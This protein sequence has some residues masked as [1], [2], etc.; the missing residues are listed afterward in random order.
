MFKYLLSVLVRRW[1]V[2]S[3]RKP[4][5]AARRAT[6]RRLKFECLEDRVVPAGTL[7]LSGTVLTLADTA[8][9]TITVGLASGNYTITDSA[10]L[11]GTITGWTISGNTATETDGNAGTITQLTFNTTGATFGNATTGIAGGAANIAITDAGTVTIGASSILTT[12]G[13]VSI[14]ATTSVVDTGTIG[15]ATNGAITISGPLSGAGNLSMGSAGASLTQ[16]TASTFSGVISGSQNLSKAGAGVL[17]LSGNSTYTGTTTITAGS[18]S[19]GTEGASAGAAG[20]LGAV[21]SSLIANDIVLNG[22]TLLLNNSLTLSANRGIVLGPTGTTAGSGEIDVAA[23]KV[24]TIA[25]IIANNGNSGTNDT[26]IVGSS[27]NTGILVL[28]GNDTY[29]GGTS[30]NDGEILI[31][32]NTALGTGKL[33]VG[34]GV[35]SATTVGANA[36]FLYL[37]GSANMTVAN[38]IALPA[39]T[40]ATYYT[41]QAPNVAGKTENLSGVISGGNANLGL[42][43][44]SA[45]SGDTTTVNELSGTNTFTAGKFVIVYR[46]CILVTSSSSLGATSNTLELSAPVNSTS[47]NLQFTAGVA[48]SN[49]IYLNASPATVNASGFNVTLSGVISNADPFEEV[50]TGSLTLTNTDTYTGATTIAG[51]T[52]YVNGTLSATAS[53]SVSSGA[54]LAGTGTINSAATVTVTG[55]LNP[56]NGTNPGV[57]TLGS[58]A[59]GSGGKYNVIL[60]GVTA[61]P[62]T[63]YDEVVAAGTVNLTNAS[64]TL[65]S[66]TAANINAGI[67]MLGIKNNGTAAVTGT[68]TSQAEG[69][70]ITLGGIN[71]TVSYI[72]GDG[73]D[74]T[75]TRQVTANESGSNSPIVV[76]ATYTNSTPGWGTYAFAT[77]GSALSAVAAGTAGSTGTVGYGPDTVIY[78]DPGAYTEDDVISGQVTLAINATGAGG[79]GPVTIGSLA[80]TVTNAALELTSGSMLVTGDTNNTSFSS[81]IGGPG[82]LEL[83]GTGTFTLNNASNSYTGGT[84]VNGGTLTLGAVGALPSN[85]TFASDTSVTVNTPG[86]FNLNAKTESI[87]GLSG[88]GT[89][90][91]AITGSTSVTLTVGTSNVTSSFG[92]ILENSS[93]AGTGLLGLTK[94]GSGAFTLTGV[95]STY[96]GVTTVS[97]GTLSVMSLA[98]G[99]VASSIGQSTNAQG[100]LVIQN[101]ADFQYA[102]VGSTSSTNRNFTIGTGGAVFQVSAANSTVNDSGLVYSSG[103]NF[104]MEGDG[105]LN[106]TANNALYTDFLTGSITVETGAV[107]SG[108]LG[109]AT[110]ELTRSSASSHLMTLNAGTFLNSSGTIE[111][112][113]T[114]SA[115]F[116]AISGA[117]TINL[118]STT[119][120][121]TTKPDIY[122]NFGSTAGSSADDGDN[123]SANINLGS[124]PRYIAGMTEHNS[125]PAYGQYADSAFT[126]VISGSPGSSLV[127]VGQDN[128]NPANGNN[129]MQMPYFLDNAANTFTG[130][131]QIQAGSLY[132]S[133]STSINGNSLLFNPTGVGAVTVTSGGSAYTSAPTVAFSGGG[134]S[135]AAGTAVLTSGAVSSVTITSFGTGYTSVP[136]VSFSGGGGS[137]AAGTSVIANARFYLDGNSPSIGDLNSTGPG[138]VG[139][140][141]IANSPGYAVAPGPATLTIAPTTTD[142]FN[143][144]I[145]EGG[146]APYLDGTTVTDIPGNLSLVINGTGS[147]TLSGLTNVTGTVNVTNG[148][149][150]A[151]GSFTASGVGA[152]TI[153]STAT[154]SSGS[155]TANAMTLGAAVVVNGALVPGGND[156]G[157]TI[158]T[159]G[160]SFGAGGVLSVDLLGNSPGIATGYDQIIANGPVNLTGAVLNL[161][162]VTTANLNPGNPLILIQGN[163]PVTGIF[164]SITGSNVSYT[165]LAEGSTITIGAGSN[166]VNFT[167]SYVGG[168]SG[169]NVTLTRQSGTTYTVDPSFNS[170]TP[171]WQTTTFSTM[172]SCLAVAQPY[173]TIDVDPG[174]YPED[175]V[176][177]QPETIQIQPG[178]VSFNS[179]AD[180]ESSNVLDLLGNLSVGADNATTT[181]SSEITGAGSLTQTGTGVFTLGGFNSFTGGLFINAGSVHSGS[182]AAGGTGGLTV[183][184]GADFQLDGHSQTFTSVSNSGTIENNSATP[185]TLSFAT[186]NNTFTGVFNNGAAGGAL[187]LTITGSGTMVL[188]GASNYSGSTNDN[189]VGLQAGS[190]T[191]LGVNSTTTLNNGASLALEGFNLSVG[192]IAGSG[193]VSNGGTT[194]AVLT[195]GGDGTSTVSTGLFSDGGAGTLALLKTGAGIFQMNDAN[196]YTG[197]TTVSQ[198]ALETTSGTGWGAGAITLADASSGS[199]PIGLLLGNSVNLYNPITVTNNGTG[200]VTIGTAVYTATTNVAYFYSNITLGRSVTFQGGNTL[201]TGFIGYITGPGGIT[202]TTAS[203]TSRVALDRS[204]TASP[205]NNWAGNLT[206]GAG[207]LVEVEIATADGNTEIPDG[208]TVNFANA[209]STLAFAPVGADTETVNALVSQAAGAGVVEPFYGVNTSTFSLIIGAGDGSGAYSGTIIADAG[210]AIDLLSLTKVGT[211]TQTLSG[212]N[213][214][215]AGTTVQGGTLLVNNASGSGLGTGSVTVGPEGVLGGTGSF[216]GAV[217]VNG[218]LAPGGVG[219]TSKFGTGNLT[220]GTGGLLDVDINGTT[221]GTNYDQVD[222]TGTANLTNGNLVINAGAGLTQ[223]STFTILT[224]TG[225]LSG[226]FADGTTIVAANNPQD[227][228]TVSVTTGTGGS[229]KLT[230]ASVAGAGPVLDFTSG[231]INFYAVAG[232]TDGMT[233]SNNAGVYTVADSAGAIALTSNATA[234][235]WVVNG[236]GSVTGPSAGTTVTAI[237]LNLGD[238]ADTIAGLSAGTNVTVDG[239]GTLT[240]AGATTTTGN[241]LIEGFTN[242]A[243]QSTVSAAAITTSLPG[244]ITATSSSQLDATTLTLGAEGGIGT[245]AN[246]VLTNAATITTASAGPV[247]LTEAAGGAITSSTTGLNDIN[248]TN[249]T[250]SLTVTGTTTDGNIIVN[251]QGS[252]L[253]LTATAGGFGNITATNAAGTLTIAGATAATGF[254]NISLSSGGGVA[255]NANVGSSA[256][257]G[258]I[259]ISADTAGTGSAGYTQATT[260]ILQTTNTSATGI[261]INVNTASGGTGNAVLGGAIVGTATAGT[262]TV[263]ANGGSIVDNSAFTFPNHTAATSPTWAITAFSTVF[264]TSGAGSIGASQLQPLIVNTPNNAATGSFVAGSGGIYVLSF[265][266]GG[267]GSGGSGFGYFQVITQAIAAGAGNIWIQTTNE[268][269]HGLV[270]NGPVWTQ[271]GNIEL[272]SNNSLTMNANAVVGGTLNTQQFSGNVLMHVNMVLTGDQ[273]L[274]MN[275]AS[276]I[277]TTSTAAN[278]VVVHAYPTTTLGGIQVGN[279]TVGNGGGIQLY[280]AFNASQEPVQS[281]PVTDVT[282]PTNPTRSGSITQDSG[283]LLNAGATGTITLEAASLGVTTEGNVGF[284][285]SIQTNAGTVDAVSTNEASAINGYINVTNEGPANFTASSTAVSGPNT[286]GTI[287]LTTNTGPLTVAGV[288]TTSGAGITL[289]GAGGVALASGATLGNSAAGTAITI[290]A[291][292]PFIGVSGSSLRLNINGTGNGGTNYD[293]LNV[294]GDLNL[295]GMTPQVYL[296]SGYTPQV[297]DT[298]MVATYSGNLL[299]YFGSDTATTQN[300]FA[301]ANAPQV[302]LKAIY[303]NAGVVELTVDKINAVTTTSVSVNQT[304]PYTTTTPLTFTATVSGNPGVGTVTFYAGPGQTNQIGQ[305]V[306]VTGG[307]ATSASYTFPAGTNTVVTAVY[308]GGTGFAGSQGTTSSFNVS[309]TSTTTTLTDNGP[310]PSTTTQSISLTATVSGGVPNGETVSLDYLSGSTVMTVTTGLTSGGNGTVNFSVPAGTLIPG[311]YNLYAAYPGDSTYASSSSTPNSNTTQMV[312]LTPTITNLTDNGPNPATTTQTISLTASVT[313]VGNVPNGETVALDYLSGM[314]VTQVT[315]GTTSGG[316]GTVNFTV[317]AG[318]LTPGTYNLYAAYP[319]DSTYAN[320]QSTPNSNT[321]QVVANLTATTA[322][323]SAVTAPNPSNAMQALTFNVQVSGGTP[324]GTVEIV[325]TSNSN[326]VVASGTLT[327]G[328]NGSINLTIPSDTI[329]AGLHN[330]QAV[331]L[332][333]SNYAPSTPANT[334]AQQVNLVIIAATV[335]GNPGNTTITSASQDPNT[336]LVTITTAAANGFVANQAVKI[337]VTGQTGYNGIFDVTPV[338]GTND[339]EFTY[340]DNNASNLPSASAGTAVSALSGNQ[341]SMVTNVVY[342]FSEPVTT[343]TASDFTLGLQSGVSVNG[344]AGQ[345]VGNT[346]GVN[347]TVTNPSGDGMTWVVGFSGTGITA[348]SLSNGVYTMLA[349]TNLITSMANPTQTAQA[350]STDT[351]A[352]MFGSVAGDVTVSNNTTITVKA[353]NANAA[354]AEIGLLPGAPNYEAYFDASGAGTRSIN[355]SDLSKVEADIGETYTSFLSTI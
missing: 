335:D 318:A 118:V 351:F 326:A 32:S 167:L 129:Y 101:G 320:S 352:R 329:Y 288:N 275:A 150:N 156:A 105:T 183:A 337:T 70:T 342:V 311:T 260:A 46:G 346:T 98:N 199:S 350:R 302:L 103:N 81:V 115:Q 57:L 220:F 121:N 92:G 116:S 202:T 283:T 308:S 265:G 126:G 316:N 23:G 186:T 165:S 247:Y 322:T 144:S 293:Q 266:N 33:T 191:A 278:A 88:T 344:G 38:A 300:D 225:A 166:A 327:A 254:G 333:D 117:G 330:L 99:G 18:L 211:G 37:N 58:L 279:I 138:G 238:G 137:G 140:N 104:T 332:G 197:G 145:V 15:S 40:T 328:E 271:S 241:L 264:N 50:G 52:M 305:P 72:G 91:D 22:G 246:N 204:S 317:P 152:D 198:G 20:N 314:S 221:V 249:L 9:P 178:S 109:I 347:L 79:S 3:S 48:L 187:G 192:S 251:N 341:R 217:A 228:F 65:G 27:G 53:V 338:S 30:E 168:A 203:G 321:T 294:S 182:T 161:A 21:P 301:A 303:S 222:V 10:G 259:A 281:P 169:A 252:G 296:G 170:S 273:S 289:N 280:A 69:S 270:I 93:G 287:S 248:L 263:N 8:A 63:T 353:A 14:T 2:L 153:G 214:Y 66:Q 244:T 107:G 292:G 80:D 257:S 12:T 171:G 285:G 130:S 200:T 232:A 28:S 67:P 34:L 61:Y 319:G 194:N 174:N 219:A 5:R 343:L 71:Y 25:G 83:V 16:T 201:I 36:P 147:L 354:Q 336:G 43:L 184:Q 134:G 112:I 76:D 250:G 315:T 41:I 143:G 267:F 164:S 309:L 97:G 210:S 151:T 160:L 212:V 159:A 31:T 310:N 269:N 284:G 114:T 39:P 87:V 297:G 205:V 78:V 77:I 286:G 243:V 324:T 339:T 124:S 245:S 29:S 47:G 94:T 113:A 348:G 272:D 223:G 54:T 231:A 295:G 291:T 26:L 185:A 224:A 128:Y 253:T 4:N 209:T 193:T 154:L 86:I 340:Q 334:I 146:S 13:T 180:T 60:N 226:A 119:D 216:T 142:T 234:A 262:Y 331:Y 240:I 96:T 189:G 215:T 111:T 133:S 258:T 122:F 304:G 306:N 163:S 239:T 110:I 177:S 136:T 282:N 190:T 82:A 276:S 123:I 89:V 298:F 242:L 261:V 68:F 188:D 84:T 235:G 11:S 139:V 229:V 6:S 149:L 148:I 173:S 1:A 141:V 42:I 175:V 17:T 157:G 95:A 135:G 51:G 195:V 102:A 100:N 64:L 44:D 277:T 274:V 7:S 237:D 45:V 73:N 62:T 207:S 206:I 236:D 312:T 172:A 313:G 355:A 179:L 325:D 162:N 35:N 106:F 90:E 155:G 56:G 290:S 75:L 349:N 19:V 125:V 127:L 230:L 268:S 158:T 218:A 256:D 108:A 132:L 131:I 213:T 345:T 196:T 255:V 299:G 176:V 120:N 85:N 59:F 181:F 233:V 227:V 307:S 49:P 24:P 74:V 323:L 208:A 55:T